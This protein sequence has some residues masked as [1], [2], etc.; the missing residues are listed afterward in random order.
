MLLRAG[1]EAAAETLSEEQDRQ[2]PGEQ[3]E[4]ISIIEETRNMKPAA[5]WMGSLSARR[6]GIIGFSS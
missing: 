6:T 1:Q 3:M 2:L 4:L 5:G